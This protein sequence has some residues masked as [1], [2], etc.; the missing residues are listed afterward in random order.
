MLDD[1]SDL[2]QEAASPYLTREMLAPL[3]PDPVIEA[4]KRDVDFSLVER[5]LRLTV[6]ERAQQLVN[7]TDFLRK[8]RPLVRDQS[9]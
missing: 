9:K 6:A 5:N 8:F 7:A 1:S 4:F 3:A 2:L